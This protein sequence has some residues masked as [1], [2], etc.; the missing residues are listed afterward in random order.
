LLPGGRTTISPEQSTDEIG[1][2]ASEKAISQDQA[3]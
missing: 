3:H 2:I 1:G